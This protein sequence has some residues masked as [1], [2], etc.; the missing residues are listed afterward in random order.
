MVLKVIHNVLQDVLVRLRDSSSSSKAWW[1]G[2]AAV[3]E[4][5]LGMPTTFNM[6]NTAHGYQ[7]NPAS[8]A[9]PTHAATTLQGLARVPALACMS[10]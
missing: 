8:L 2:M 4:F 6:L 3:S 9:K 1:Y 5:I 7:L 10:G